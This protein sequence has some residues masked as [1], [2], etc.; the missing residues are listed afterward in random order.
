MQRK[1]MPIQAHREVQH[2]DQD[3]QQR[4]KD[5]SLHPALLAGAFCDISKAGGDSQPQN[6]EQEKAS[7]NVGEKIERIAG[8]R[9]SHRFF[10][11]FVRERVLFRS[12]LFRSADDERRNLGRRRQ[13]RGGFGRT[14]LRGRSQ[15]RFRN[16]GQGQE[17]EKKE[18]T[19]R[20]GETVR[21]KP[22]P[23]RNALKFIAIQFPRIYMAWAN[24]AVSMQHELFECKISIPRIGRNNREK[25][26]CPAKQMRW[27]SRCGYWM[28]RLQAEIAYRAAGRETDVH[29]R[30][31]AFEF[32]VTVAMKKIGGADGDSGG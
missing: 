13:L 25:R 24:G 30:G 22:P 12:R 11:F 8:A 5:Q 14:I 9:I 4:H 32:V 28:G 19:E 6:E 20:Q 18:G 23:H 21:E 17:Q 16:P 15:L 10:I 2:V 29:E 26:F 31:P 1:P 27:A 7:Q 3:K